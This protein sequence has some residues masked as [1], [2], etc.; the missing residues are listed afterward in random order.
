MATGAGY[1]RGGVRAATERGRIQDFLDMGRSTLQQPVV[2]SKGND[3]IQN[4]GTA[5]R[6]QKRA[7]LA[8]NTIDRDSDT[9]ITL[10]REAGLLRERIADYAKSLMS[11]SVGFAR[12]VAGESKKA[13]RYESGLLDKKGSLLPS[14]QQ[15]ITGEKISDARSVLAEANRYVQRVA[16]ITQ[17][18]GVNTQEIQNYQTE[19]NTE[20]AALRSGL[21]VQ[22]RDHDHYS[23]ERVQKHVGRVTT[24][25]LKRRVRVQSMSRDLAALRKRR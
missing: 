19:V 21:Q 10:N 15:K 5:L 22:K 1:A 16:S 3:P 14:T 4:L 24:E 12:M 7:E 8:L 13:V 9:Y 2:Y 11:A 23:A 6:Y 20:L 18:F 25:D 17:R